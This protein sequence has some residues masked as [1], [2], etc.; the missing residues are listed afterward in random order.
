MCFILLYFSPSF[1]L[2][3]SFWAEW[4]CSGLHASL[5][6]CVSVPSY[7]KCI[8]IS[9]VCIYSLQSLRC[10]VAETTLV[11]VSPGPSTI[12]YRLGYSRNVDLNVM[13][14]S[15]SAL[16]FHCCSSI[17]NAFLTPLPLFLPLVQSEWCFPKS[18][19][20]RITYF[21]KHIGS[22]ACRVFQVLA[23]SNLTSYLFLC[24]PVTWLTVP[25][26]SPVPP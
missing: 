5:Q 24:S 10:L 7:M 3:L 1:V 26:I 19:S 13:K 20:D 9:T 16:C 6:L 12:A 23:S 15:R 11:R 22:W 18:K 8:G 4:C 2:F 25:R 21:I 17:L 14:L